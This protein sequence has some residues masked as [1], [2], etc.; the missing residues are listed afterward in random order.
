MT[1]ENILDA[2]QL[3]GT[4]H[5][6]TAMP[7]K[8]ATPNRREDIPAFVHVCETEAQHSSTA[9]QPTNS[10]EYGQ[11]SRPDVVKVMRKLSDAVCVG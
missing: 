5:S 6:A 4:T 9:A 10:N 3:T 11:G 2:R 7:G 8:T 1:D